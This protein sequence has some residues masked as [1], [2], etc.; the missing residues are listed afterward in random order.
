MITQSMRTLARPARVYLAA[1]L[2]ASLLVTLL[3]LLAPP[4]TGEQAGLTVLL[5]VASI[6]GQLFEVRTPN[7]KAYVVTPA[8]LAAAAMLLPPLSLV[9][10]VAL[11][12]AVEQLVKP[13][14]RYVQAFNTASH[15]LAT[16]AAWAGAQ[17]VLAATGR[18]Y[19]LDGG[20]RIALAGL[21]VVVVGML[22]NH[23][24]LAVALRLARGIRIRD[25]GLFR[26]EGL[27]TDS[28]LLSVGI[29]AAKLWWESPGMVPFALVPLVLLHRALHVPA[30]Q[31]ASRTDSKTGLFNSEYFR[32]LAA[33]EVRRSERTGTLV[34]VLVADLDYLRDINNAYGHLAGDVVL[35]G[36]A[37][38]LR[39]EVREYDVVSRFG[40]EEFAVLLPG[41]SAMEGL[42]IAERIRARVARREFEVRT[43]PEAIRATLSLGVATFPYHGRD[44]PDLLHR[45]DLAVYRAKEEGRNLVRLADPSDDAN[46][47]PNPPPALAS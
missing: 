41:T 23:V 10:V 31:L 5:A 21:V 15:L 17:L 2:V 32:E 27:V 25:T 26:V 40:G 45:A 24:T 6:L 4:H 19:R 33:A 14:P 37:A 30:L 12:F 46:A 35:A 3:S 16:V 38:V 44:L 13:K 43:A 36:V 29:S 39:E 1:V 8:F 9:L 20:G 11:P 42:A 47:A 22:V 7:N 34:T 28:A 18:A